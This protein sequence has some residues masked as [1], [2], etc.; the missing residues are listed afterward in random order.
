[1][2]TTD[3]SLPEQLLFQPDGHLTDAALACAA[4][5][6]LDLLHAAHVR[7]HQHLDDCEPC[8]HRLG[9]AALFSVLAGDALRERPL[10]AAISVARPVSVPAVSAVIAVRKRRPFP[11]AAIAAAL[12]L[13]VLTAGPS[14]LG[15]LRSVPGALAAVPF[16][17]RVAGA[18]V[19]A[20]W[21]HGP[22]VVLVKGVSALL[23]LA[24]GLQ[25]ARVTSR[26]RSLQQGGV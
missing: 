4:D 22:T 13:A 10:A 17:L 6:E 16:L 7:A 3:H 26:S 20:P 9:E 24:V 2:K 5:G 12:T 21:G 14:L 1:M 11:V 25:I 8:A 18:F 15:T 23:L 19:R